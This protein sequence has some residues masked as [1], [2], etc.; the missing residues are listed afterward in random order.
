VPQSRHDQLP[1]GAFAAVELDPFI[2]ILN[3]APLPLGLGDLAVLPAVRGKSLHPRLHARATAADGDETD[4]ALGHV[5]QAGMGGR[6]RV[7]QQA[8]RVV[9]RLHLPVVGGPGNH[10]VGLASQE[11]GG[12]VTDHPP[13]D[14]VRQKCHHPVEGQVPRCPP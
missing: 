12:R 9:P 14:R 7:E 6:T 13:A 4:L 5:A 2:D 11:V 1:H 8:S 3:L 10:A